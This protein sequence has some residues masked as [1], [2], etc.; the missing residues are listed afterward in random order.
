MK[1]TRAQAR[2][3]ML[4]HH[5]LFPPRNLHGKEGILAYIDHV[6]CIQFDPINIVGRNPDLVL[7]SR[8]KKYKPSYLEELLYEQRVLMDGWDK[9]ASIY[10]A[11]DWP[12]FHRFRTAQKNRRQERRPPSDAIENVLEELKNHGP[13]SSLHFKNS[14][15]I[16]W[17][18]GPTKIARAVLEYLY[19]T[20]RIG[21]DHRI[22]SRRVFDLT[23]NLLPDELHNQPDPFESIQDYQDW[24]TLRRVGSLGI[25]DSKSGE[26]WLG[27]LSYKSQ[28]RKKSLDRLTNTNQLVKFHIEDLAS[29]E[30]YIRKQDFPTLENIETGSI[31]PNE[32]AIIAPLD[33]LTWN[34]S[35]I[36]ELFNFEYV[37][38]IYKPKKDRKY[39]YY[40]LPVLYHDRFIARFE[41]SFDKKNKA[42]SIL[43]WWWE[44]DV[45]PDA[46]MVNALIRCF[47][48]F[49]TYLNVMSVTSAENI[50]KDKRLSWLNE[51]HS[52]VLD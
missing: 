52:E 32:A 40:V 27:I 19:F 25:A 1:I 6:G 22:S 31:S 33:N 26:Y 23:E 9:Q 51:I 8:I 43:N 48:S 4:L 2:T 15:K 17:Y 20:G 13:L 29:R 28:D 30:F 45:V 16:D 18:W 11:R 44:N 47:N 35:L 39:G 7:Q 49:V 42:F 3:F 24:H 41:P 5:G 14:E 38:E 36:K 46:L 37:W 12:F 34:R 21:I 50:K 10:H